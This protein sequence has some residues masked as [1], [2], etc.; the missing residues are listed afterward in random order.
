MQSREFSR[1]ILGAIGVAL[2]LSTTPSTDAASA[3]DDALQGFSAARLQR[4]TQGLQGWVDRKEVPG[5]VTIIARH[6]RIVQTNALGWQDMESKIPM[7]GDTIFRLASMSKPITAV[8]TMMLVEEGKIRLDDPLEKWLPELAN[9]RVSR[10]ADG[11]MDDTYP[12]PRS[13]TV[14]D[15]LTHRSGLPS[16][17]TGGSM[18]GVGDPPDEWIR[19]LG[20][21]PLNYEPGTRWNYGLNFEVLGVLIARVSGMNFADFLQTRLFEPLGMKDTG[22]WVTPEKRSRFAVNYERDPKTGDYEV[23]HVGPPELWVRPPIFPSG[24]SGLVSTAEDYRKFAQMLV[25]DGKLGN[26]RILSRNSTELMTT[27]FLTPEQRKAESFPFGRDGNLNWETWG[28]G[29]G[30]SVLKD[31]TKLNSLGSVGSFRWPGYFGVSW[32]G[33]RKE[34]L[35][36][37]LMIQDAGAEK[38]M[39]DFS[40]LAY[41]AI[42]D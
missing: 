14:L 42:D 28:F 4:V 29:L 17:F 35:V 1:N 31:P 26:V 6:G 8:A 38:I 30:M 5:V 36:L 12:S 40:T 9:R 10:K 2:A 19:R 23:S 37:I 18:L 16:G 7:R 22:F 3:I 41:Q 32:I 15:L 24:G 27:D 33:D 21:L 34:D 11:S 13:I 20:T 39:A 25:N